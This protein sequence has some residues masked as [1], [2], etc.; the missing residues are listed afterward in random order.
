MA[1][2]KN[3]GGDKKPQ[4]KVQDLETKKDPQGGVRKAGKDQQEFNILKSDG[5]GQK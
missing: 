4:L 1:N 5:P 3:D 2:Q